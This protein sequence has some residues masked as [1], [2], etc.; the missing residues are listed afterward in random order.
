MSNQQQYIE[1]YWRDATPADAIKDPPMVARFQHEGYKTWIIDKLIYWD[2]SD[3]PWHRDDDVCYERCQVYDAPDPGEGWRLIDTASE[4]PQDGDEV[5]ANSGWHRRSIVQF[6]E[7]VYRRRIEQPKPEPKYVPFRWEDREQLRG[8]WVT[9][10]H[11][12]GL[13]IESHVDHLNERRDGGLWFKSHD[14]KWLLLKAIFLDTG[15]PVG[16]KV[17]Q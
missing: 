6:G 1:R 15:E 12:N 14:A 8:R 17:T 5:L 7:A 3:D 2:R 4:A 10:K 11:D 9:W 16:K 13:M